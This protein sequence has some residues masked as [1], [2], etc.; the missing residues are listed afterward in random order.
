METPDNR[1]KRERDWF[2]IGFQPI[3]VDFTKSGSWF[4]V[5][6]LM[7]VGFSVSSRLFY[8]S[9]LTRFLALLGRVPKP[10]CSP[11][12][13]TPKAPFCF[14]LMTSPPLFSRSGQLSV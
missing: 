4:V 12:V 7:E 5:Y 3:F 13:T 10:L 6:T 14:L 9:F 8:T 2:R 1:N 11:V